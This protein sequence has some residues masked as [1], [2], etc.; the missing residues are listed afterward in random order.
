MQIPP[1]SLPHQEPVAARNLAAP[2]GL[3][4]TALLGSGASSA[5]SAQGGPSIGEGQPPGH[6]WCSEIRLELLSSLAVAETG[7]GV[8]G[9]QG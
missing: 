3:P 1:T 7:L 8:H 5:N 9:F 2:T 4:K 6:P